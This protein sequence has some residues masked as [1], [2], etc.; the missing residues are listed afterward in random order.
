MP[1]DLVL[2]QTT[3]W[4]LSF[5]TNI[6]CLSSPFLLTSVR[7]GRSLPGRDLVIRRLVGGHAAARHFAPDDWLLCN[8]LLMDLNVRP[9]TA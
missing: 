3:T 1:E 2:D 6:P 7:S 8:A 9:Y 4:E 5:P